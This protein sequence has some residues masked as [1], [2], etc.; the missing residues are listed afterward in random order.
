MH[1]VCLLLSLTAWVAVLL[2]RHRDRLKL[3][4]IEQQLAEAAQGLLGLCQAM[5]RL[6]RH[7]DYMAPAENEAKLN[8]LD[9]RHHVLSL[10]NRGLSCQ[11]IAERLHVARGEVELFLNLERLRANGESTQRRTV[12]NSSLN[13][14]YARAWQVARIGAER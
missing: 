4:R 3:R 12:T 2:L 7:K 8:W 9:K 13:S 14:G 1:E 6:D 5:E 10:A 11:Q